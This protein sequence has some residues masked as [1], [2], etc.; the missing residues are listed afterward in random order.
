M[1]SANAAASPTL[2]SVCEN[3]ARKEDNLL[4]TNVL[5]PTPA[6]RCEAM[7]EH[8]LRMS[9]ITPATEN[10]MVVPG[11]YDVIYSIR[12]GDQ[13]PQNE[14]ATVMSQVQITN[15][16]E[17]L[18]I[19]IQNSSFDGTWR[20]SVDGNLDDFPSTVYQ[21]GEMSLRTEEGDQIPLGPT[22]AATGPVN[23]IAGTYDVLYSHRT[24]GPSGPLV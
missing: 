7:E 14:N 18:N 24:P 2:N 16:P 8:K 6:L 11:I 15:S 13:L 23:V 1:A 22:H 20:L 21:R 10:V 9:A 17:V 12:E 3:L 4:S 5:M 19:N